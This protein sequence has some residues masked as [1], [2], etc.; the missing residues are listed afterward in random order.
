M[1]WTPWSRVERGRACCAASRSEACAR[2]NREKQQRRHTHAG[3]VVPGSCRVMLWRCVGPWWERTAL[4]VEMSRRVSPRVCALFP[5]SCPSLGV[6]RRTWAS[7]RTIVALESPCREHRYVRSAEEMFHWKACSDAG[8]PVRACLREGCFKLTISLI[9]SSLCSAR[10]SSS[11]TKKPQQSSI[12]HILVSSG[13]DP[14]ESD[15]ASALGQ[16]KKSCPQLHTLRFLLARAGFSGN[17]TL[18]G[19]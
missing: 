17:Q 3:A 13:P 12:A 1:S 19:A 5:S 2:P 11:Q 7:Q 16:Q 14:A 15:G 18:R 4:E 8:T 9:S 10:S 6:P